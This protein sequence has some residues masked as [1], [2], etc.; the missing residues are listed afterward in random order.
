MRISRLFCCAFLLASPAAAEQAPKPIPMP[1][2]DEARHAGDSEIAV[3]AGGC[4]WGMQA[5]FERVHGVKAVTAGFSGAPA[6]GEDQ[7]IHSSSGT[8]AEA[9]RI[10]FD[11]AQLTYGQILQIYFSVAH[12]PTQVDR[13]GPDV[14]P[15]YRSAIYFDNNDQ[16]RIAENYIAQL[17]SAGVFP[18]PI[19]TQVVPLT[20]F[21]RVMSSQQ[22]Y[23]RKN[24]TL[25]YVL[26]V[27]M[28]RIAALKR[29]YPGIY[30]DQPLTYSD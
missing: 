15:Q 9:V 10:E 29:I 19:A 27:D 4:Y 11:P 24:P 17:Q 12:D 21:H 18:A 22:D 14:G 8:P 2:S 6:S 5:I 16:K 7:L 23:V 13:Q 25:P 1:S 26:G 3:L 28:P 20:G 30:L